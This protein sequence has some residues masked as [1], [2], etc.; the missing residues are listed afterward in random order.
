MHAP[1]FGITSLVGGDELQRLTARLLSEHFANIA[2]GGAPTTKIASP[3]TE[4]HQR[5][6]APVVQAQLSRAPAA[7]PAPV[8]PV[9][10][11]V[12]FDPLMARRQ[13]T[14]RSFKDWY[15]ADRGVDL[16]ES[17]TYTDSGGARWGAMP[18]FPTAVGMGTRELMLVP[19][20]RSAGIG[21][22]L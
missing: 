21:G 16:P 2:S 18:Q 20:L 11:S 15:G 4:H 12:E 7:Q 6:S 1:D 8:P 5:S 9:Q 19:S 22:L 10:D 13:H 17:I 14:Q 3:P